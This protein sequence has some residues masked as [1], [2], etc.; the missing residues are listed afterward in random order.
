MTTTTDTPHPAPIPTPVGLQVINTV[1]VSGIVVFHVWQEFHWKSTPKEA[2]IGTDDANS[3]MVAEHI[4]DYGKPMPKEK[5]NVAFCESAIATV[6]TEVPKDQKIYMRWWLEDK[7]GKQI[8]E[9]P[10]FTKDNAKNKKADAQVKTG[11]Y[12]WRWDGRKLNDHKRL[13]F[14]RNEPC[15][16]RI[17]ITSEA[18]RSIPVNAME[19][20]RINVMGDPYKLWVVGEPKADADLDA[21][22]NSMAGNKKG[23]WLNSAGNSLQADCWIKVYRG[24]DSPGSDDQLVFLGHGAIEA[25]DVETDQEKGAAAR[26]GAIATPH[27][28]EHKAYVRK[29]THGGKK[30]WL[31]ELIDAPNKTGNDAYLISLAP[32]D[33]APPANNPFCDIKKNEPF[34]D[35]VH[36]HQSFPEGTN[37]HILEASSV[38]CTTV[39]NLSDRTHDNPASTRGD[40]VSNRASFGLWVTEAVPGDASNK[41]W[42][43][44][45]PDSRPGTFLN[46]QNRR[47]IVSDALRP[48]DYDNVRLS[49]LQ[50]TQAATVFDDTQ[51]IQF[52]AQHALFGGFLEHEIPLSPTVHAEPD[53]PDMDTNPKLRI[54]CILRE[55]PEA[56]KY[57]Q[58]HRLIAFGHSVDS[59]G[60]K[61]I[62]LSAFMPR[63]VMRRW[64]GHWRNLLIAGQTE[65]AWFIEKRGGAGTAQN[66]AWVSKKPTAPA[67][68]VKLPS[69]QIGK[70]GG[71]SVIG[72]FTVKAG[73]SAGTLVSVFKYRVKLHPDHSETTSLWEP[74][75]GRQDMLTVIQSTL[76]GNGSPAQVDD[77]EI[78]KIGNQHYLVGSTELEIMPVTVDYGGPNDPNDSSVV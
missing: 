15:I 43:P 25:T 55:A 32:A 41:L 30:F 59:I 69:D 14:M 58:Y 42:G 50:V 4:D 48:D 77:E 75:A 21:Q 67:E 40:I 73:A 3:K 66:V 62:K 65:Y 61:S 23:R 24:V 64:N 22:V 68:Y 36:T 1:N 46:K 33:G 63:K 38:G 9:H 39:V 2:Y 26:W 16:S 44:P 51:H 74:L 29:G 10:K 52:T 70:A 20:A 45:L 47:T 53:A 60:D 7:D 37:E 49:P 19:T 11:K 6:K 35:G 17:A 5:L 57:W 31:C 56:S 76:H 18:G 34:K 13:V 28:V 12:A 71:N 54:R 72:D 78:V 8:A 27:D